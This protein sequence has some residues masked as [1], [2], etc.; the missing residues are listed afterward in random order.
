MYITLVVGHSALMSV[1]LS[2][3][4]L[5]KRGR[6]P[7]NQS[8]CKSGGLEI[9]PIKNLGMAYNDTFTSRC[10]FEAESW[11]E[12]GACTERPQPNNQIPTCL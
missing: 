9:F 7:G 6:S 5:R 2:R 11:L 12:I 1:T 3:G 8:R 10:A 4:S